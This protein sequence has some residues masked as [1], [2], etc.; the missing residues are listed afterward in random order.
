MASCCTELSRHL[1]K[2]QLL[3]KVIGVNLQEAG[4]DC[5]LQAFVLHLKRRSL[6]VHPKNRSLTHWFKQLRKLGRDHLIP[7]GA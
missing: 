5:H 2:P 6:C 3:N 4:G 1:L 7:Q